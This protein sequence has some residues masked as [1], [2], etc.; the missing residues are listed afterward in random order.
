MS[1]VADGIY[2]HR[3]G[4]FS[5]VSLESCTLWQLRG[6]CPD[7]GMTNGSG[8]NKE[9]GGVRGGQR[10]VDVQTVPQLWVNIDER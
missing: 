5:R 6:S 2:A 1:P 9:R 4:R 8:D 3:R 7:T 10:K